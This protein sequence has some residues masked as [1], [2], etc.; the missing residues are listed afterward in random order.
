[1]ITAKKSRA[2][3]PKFGVWARSWRT[4]SR[5][6]S[7]RRTTRF[8]QWWSGRV[9]SCGAGS[10]TA[11]A[12]CLQPDSEE[13]SGPGCGARSGLC[14]V[15]RR[16]WRARQWAEKCCCPPLLDPGSRRT[17][18]PHL[19]SCGAGDE[20]G[21]GHAESKFGGSRVQC[22]ELVVQPI[23]GDQHPKPRSV[24][25]ASWRHTRRAHS[26]QRR[27]GQSQSMSS[28]R[29]CRPV[30]YRRWVMGNGNRQFARAGSSVP[31]VLQALS[32]KRLGVP[33]ER[34]VHCTTLDGPRCFWEPFETER[35]ST[36][37]DAS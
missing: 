5:T 36:R 34:A 2:V 8:C 20:K 19:R 28:T 22:K 27:P 12:D 10:A 31:R 30:Q 18:P 13:A 16:K 9:A 29:C 17:A 11:H 32:A 3:E 24:V 6:S 23:E 4:T 21:P 33:S 15:I 25:L 26:W 7:G 14:G 1:M 35:L 37:P